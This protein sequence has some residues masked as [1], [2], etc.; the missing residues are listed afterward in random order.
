MQ[1]LARVLQELDRGEE[2]RNWLSTAHWKRAPGNPTLRNALIV[3]LQ[4]AGRTADAAV[5][6]QQWL[7]TGPVDAST[8]AAARTAAA[9][10]ARI[11]LRLNGK[12]SQ[13]PPLKNCKNSQ[14]MIHESSARPPS[15]SN[16]ANR[17]ERSEELLRASL[18]ESPQDPV[19]REVLVHFFT[20]V[21]VPVRRSKSGISWPQVRSETPNLSDSSQTCC[22]ETD[23]S[24]RPFRPGVKRAI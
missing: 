18:A 14:P 19:A 15:F 1:R 6:L 13:R 21:S 11:F 8:V 16:C 2:A 9:L 12:T 7:E 5:R 3:A 4:A 22:S 24:S 10:V 23:F 17:L 20:A